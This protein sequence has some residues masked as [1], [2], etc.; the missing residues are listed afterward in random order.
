MDKHTPAPWKVTNLKECPTPGYAHLVGGEGI[1]THIALTVRE[2]DARLIAAAPELLAAT[3]RMLNWLE[4][5]SDEIDIDDLALQARVAIEKANSDNAPEHLA[6]SIEYARKF[7]TV[8]DLLDALKDARIA[9][10]FYRNWMKT[11]NCDPDYNTE[12]PFGI[13]AEEAARAT[14]EKA[15][16]V[17]P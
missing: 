16:G 17:Q 14:I 15:E 13:E 8:D 9:L 7:A 10:T 1:N 3:T 4:G 12:Y 6:E 11:H 2:D 5:R